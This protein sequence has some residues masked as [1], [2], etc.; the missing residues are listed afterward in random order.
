MEQFVFEAGNGAQ[1]H[2]RI[3]MPEGKP[4]AVLQVIHGMTEHM[5][6]YDALAACL[7]QQG[8]AVAGFDLRGHGLNEGDPDVASFGEGGW[9]TSLEDIRLFG[10]L[11]DERMPGVPRVLMGFSLGSFLLS[12]YLAN[13]EKDMAGAIVMGTG[14]QSGLVLSI[15]SAIV[16]GQIAKDGFDVTTPLVRKLSFETYNQKFKPNRTPS[17]WLCADDAQLDAYRADPLCRQDISSGL[18]HQLIGS[19]KRA[20]AGQLYSRWPEMPILLLSGASDPVGSFGRGVTKVEAALKAAGQPDVQLQLFHGA[21]HDVLHEE[22]TGTAMQTR[23]L[24]A[25]WVLDAVRK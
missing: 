25:R 18:F 23:Q 5:G 11:L 24:I 6:R 10:C 22:N 16:K 3:W 20:A 7:T 2:A 21:R 4:T 17:D 9:E 14:M 12:D 8:I 13:G 15:M 1:L 19:M